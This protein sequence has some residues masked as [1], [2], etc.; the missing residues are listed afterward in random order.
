MEQQII[1]NQRQ[2]EAVNLINEFIYT[3]DKEFLLTGRA[4]TGKTTTISFIDFPY[5]TIGMAISHKAKEVLRESL[6]HFDIITVASAIGLEKVDDLNTGE[7]Q[8]IP[9]GKEIVKSKLIFI[10]DEC[11]MID[12]STR[13]RLLELYPNSKFIYLG[14]IHQLPPIKDKNS[15]IFIDDKVPSIE[16]IDNMR[17][18]LESPIMTLLNNIV[19]LQLVNCDN[20]DLIKEILPKENITIDNKRLIQNMPIGEFY[21]LT[22]ETIIITYHNFKKEI[23]NNQFREKILK[24]TK[25]YEIGDRLIFNNNIYKSVSAKNTRIFTNSEIVTV[26][27]VSNAGYSFNEKLIYLEKG[28]LKE[29]NINFEMPYYLIQVQDKRDMIFVP[30]DITKFSKLLDKISNYAKQLSSYPDERKKMWRIFFKAKYA[31]Y[32]VSYAYSIT[33]HKSQ[34]STYDNVI[35]DFNDIFKSKMTMDEKLK[36]FYVACSR[37]KNNLNII[38]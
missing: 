29:E 37:A 17:T 31:F 24:F 33:S 7:T 20:I 10:V 22:G 12:T 32:D 4:G 11:S 36:C 6:P 35:V 21:R 15:N 16:L 25:T 5:T 18:G 8:F 38:F 34:G 30:S 3:D 26:T 28:E 1:L 2:K 9:F 23:L 13:E 14:D 19:K 27:S